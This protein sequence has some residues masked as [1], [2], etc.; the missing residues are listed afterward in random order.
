MHYSSSAVDNICAM[1][2]PYLF[3]NV[4]QI[5]AQ[6]AMSDG[7]LLWLNMWHIYKCIH[8]PYKSI[9]YLAYMPNILCIFVPS[10]YLAIRWGVCIAVGYVLADLCK[11]VGAVCPFI[12]LVVWLRYVMWQSYLFSN[13]FIYR[14]HA[15]YRTL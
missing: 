3:S 7:W 9:K 15:L 11:N 14:A 12:M 8:L 13:T 1:W 4:W 2:Q 5:C 6:C 10:T